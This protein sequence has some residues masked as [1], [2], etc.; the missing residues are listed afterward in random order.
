MIR[1]FVAAKFLGKAPVEA[2]RAW[3]AHISEVGVRDA[4]PGLPW[5]RSMGKPSSPI[6]G[7]DL[8]RTDPPAFGCGLGAP[9]LA[10]WHARSLRREVQMFHKTQKKG[11]ALR[12]T[13]L[14][15]ARNISCK[16]TEMVQTFFVKSKTK[17]S[18]L[19]ENVSLLTEKIQ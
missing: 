2:A 1:N 15:C 13:H 4:T 5:P 12:R 6:R 7:H 9:S 11:P 14:F 18:F 3:V 16:R 19:Q 8:F 10:L 17:E